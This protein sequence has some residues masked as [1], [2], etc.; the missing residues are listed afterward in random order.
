MVPDKK[1]SVAITTRI[2]RLAAGQVAVLTVIGVVAVMTFR[3]MAT[4]NHE[5]WFLSSA[6]VPESVIQ[7]FRANEEFYGGMSWVCGGVTAWMLFVWFGRSKSG[8]GDE[9]KAV[10]S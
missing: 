3:Q 9:G 10:S 4:D 6:T 1:K 2:R 5:A 7:R 8:N